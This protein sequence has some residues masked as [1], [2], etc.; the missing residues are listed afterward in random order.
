MVFGRIVS[1][2]DRSDQ[3]AGD[4]PI[5]PGTVT[6]QQYISLAQSRWKMAWS[7]FGSNVTFLG[8]VGEAVILNCPY[9]GTLLEVGNLKDLGRCYHC[10]AQ[11][12]GYSEGEFGYDPGEVSG[13]AFG[14]GTTRIR[15]TAYRGLDLIGSEEVL[16]TLS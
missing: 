13:I 7:A 1:Q 12:E 8:K 15:F 9:C 4:L 10:G 14:L 16:I 2:H 5:H 6:V 11:P 3:L